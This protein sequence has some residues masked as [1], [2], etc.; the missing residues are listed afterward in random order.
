LKLSDILKRINI[1]IK[2]IN[3]SEITHNIPVV[4][5]YR[6]LEINALRTQSAI[7]IYV[8]IA[9]LRFLSNLMFHIRRKISLIN[10]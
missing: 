3:I 6:F 8:T 4:N 7:L 5:I 9:I 1:E 10:Y 2:C